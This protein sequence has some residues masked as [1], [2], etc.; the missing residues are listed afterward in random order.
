M[1]LFRYFVRSRICNTKSAIKCSLGNINPKNENVE[2]N[3]RNVD[4][5]RSCLVLMF[6]VEVSAITGESK[7]RETE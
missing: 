2:E 5:R 4:M 6:L 1:A 3:P 7:L